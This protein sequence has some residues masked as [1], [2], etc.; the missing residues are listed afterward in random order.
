[1]LRRLCFRRC[2]SVCLLTTVRK[3][4]RTD[5]HEIFREGWQWTNEQTI[6]FWRRSGSG[7]RIQIPIASLVRRALAE[8]CIV[9]V[10]LV[11]V[12]L[13]NRRDHYIFILSFVLSSSFF[14]FLSSPNLSRCRLDVCHTSTHGV[15]LVRISDAGR[16]RAARGSLKT[17]DAKKSQKFAICAPSHNFVGLYLRN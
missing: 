12:A 15:A 1:M 8:V 10:L 2:L 13:W 17:Q 7:I 14:F 16:K 4:F 9:Q 5:L 3:N 11:M 6:K